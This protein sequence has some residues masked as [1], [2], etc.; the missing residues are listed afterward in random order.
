MTVCGSM[1]VEP[2]MQRVAGLL[3]AQGHPVLVPKRAEGVDYWE[4]DGAARVAA[5]RSQD[6]IRLH[7]QQIERSDAIVVVNDLCRGIHAY[8]GAN[9][10]LEIGHAFALGKPIYLLWDPWGVPDP[11]YQ[12]YIADELAA[13]EPIVLNGDLTK[14]VPV[15]TNVG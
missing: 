2:E 8:I 15:A 10:F 14:I 12:S 1:K 11:S 6:L 7:F 4:R 13:M 5:K 3:A 9:T